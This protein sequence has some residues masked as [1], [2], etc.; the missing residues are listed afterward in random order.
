MG[1]R[2]NVLRVARLTGKP[3][4]PSWVLLKIADGA[5]DDGAN[6]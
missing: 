5:D 4:T 1:V 2:V 3:S 6:A